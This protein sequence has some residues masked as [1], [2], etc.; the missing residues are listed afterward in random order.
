MRNATILAFL[1][2]CF[3]FS[4]LNEAVIDINIGIVP[5]GF[6]NVKSA[7][8]EG[9]E[10]NVYLDLKLD[11]RK[12]DNFEKKLSGLTVLLYER[13]RV[14]E[15]AVKNKLLYWGVDVILC[16]TDDDFIGNLRTNGFAVTLNQTHMH[17]VTKARPTL[18]VE[19][20][21]LVDINGLNPS[22]SLN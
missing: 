14:T 20:V 6:I 7:V 4:L 1:A 5:K 10:F 12:Q 15:E 18:S 9:T 16:K 17:H 19:L 22:R 11:Q 3:R 13:D 21:T 2:V 8:G